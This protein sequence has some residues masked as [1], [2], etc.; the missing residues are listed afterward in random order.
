MAGH[1]KW[2]KV[3]RAKGAL[4]V[5]RGKIFS[6]L[7]REIIMA[8]KAG[9]ADPSCNSRLRTAIQAAKDQ[10]MPNDNIDRAIKRGTGELEGGS[11]EEILYEGF[12]PGGV[13]LLIELATDNRNRSAADLRTIFTRNDGN[14]GSAGSV[15]HL[16]KRC[17]QI[18]V[19]KSAADEDRMLEIALEA[20]ADELSTDDEH[21]FVL[22]PPERLD[23]VS[24]SI[25]SAGLTIENQRFAYIP[26]TV[27]PVDEEATA[28][29]VL[30]LIEVLDDYDDTQHVFANFDIPDEILARLS[31]Q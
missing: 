26:Q 27:I 5:K 2:S 29:Q 28:A 20:G 7:A 4:D 23:A 24:E 18:T 25:R 31:E 21:H 6:K 3:K 22:T 16:F 8:A 15:S 14:L 19:P 9:G 30:R 11:I 12:A 10:N 13:G 1:N 17:G